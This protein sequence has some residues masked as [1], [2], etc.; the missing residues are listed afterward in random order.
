MSKLPPDHPCRHFSKAI[1]RLVHRHDNEGGLPFWDGD[2]GTKQ[3][4][5]A[6]VTVD[7][8]DEET[9]LED[10]RTAALDVDESIEDDFEPYTG[11]FLDIPGVAVDM[12]SRK[13]LLEV[14]DQMTG[15]PLL[16][17][18]CP[19]CFVTIRQLT[20]RTLDGD[21]VSGEVRRDN[22]LIDPDLTD[23]MA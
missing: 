19:Y 7:R 11:I 23:S 17:G 4:S 8:F 9:R 5:T 10:D 21:F 15:D 22:H 13:A 1:D 3:T 2:S 14:R 18:T 6:A 20:G 12:G 16:R